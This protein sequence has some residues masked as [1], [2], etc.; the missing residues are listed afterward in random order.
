LKNQEKGASKIWKSLFL[1][2][3]YAMHKK[4]AE[5]TINLLGYHLKTPPRYAGMLAT[6]F[7]PWTNETIED[8]DSVVYTPMMPSAPLTPRGFAH[9]SEKDTVHRML[10]RASRSGI[11]TE[12]HLV[13]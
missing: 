2:G 5:N 12:Q 11:G 8:M 3:S 1:S 6:L 13:H 7:I 9:V 4:R 10:C